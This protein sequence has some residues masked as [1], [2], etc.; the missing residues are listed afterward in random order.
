M[1]K[2]RINW[3]NKT[4]KLKLISL[5][6]QQ[7]RLRKVTSH[8]DHFPRSHLPFHDLRKEIGWCCSLQK[9]QQF[10]TDTSIAEQEMKPFSST[11]VYN[12][13]TYYSK[14][15]FSMLW[16]FWFS[17]YLIPSGVNHSTGSI[18]FPFLVCKPTSIGVAN[19]KLDLR[20]AETPRCPRS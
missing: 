11:Y 19:G 18:W 12:D 16:L 10:C 17:F 5:S 2:C 15:T 9:L 6:N 13:N 4:D 7:L 8:G 20:L 3:V 14:S 1:W